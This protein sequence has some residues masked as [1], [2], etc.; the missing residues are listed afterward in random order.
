M[1]DY[2]Y[3]SSGRVADLGTNN[4]REC[5]IWWRICKSVNNSNF[6][7]V[8]ID[9]PAMHRIPNVMTGASFEYNILPMTVTI[10]SS[11]AIMEESLNSKRLRLI[12]VFSRN[13]VS[14]DC[15][16]VRLSIW[17]ARHTYRKELFAY[18]SVEENICR[19]IWT[20]TSLFGLFV[21]FGVLTD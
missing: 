19:L 16:I 5:C 17:F 12:A 15:I 14:R 6:E 8:V 7:R 10:A 1:R 4:Y 3:C 11:F 20:T 2:L 21:E 18:R 9:S 13:R